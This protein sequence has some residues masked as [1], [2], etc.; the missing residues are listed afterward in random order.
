MSAI[1]NYAD[2]RGVTSNNVITMIIRTG[3][4]PGPNPRPLVRSSVNPDRRGNAQPLRWR[5]L[6]PSFAPR[7]RFAART[8]GRLGGCGGGGGDKPHD[9]GRAAWPDEQ[10]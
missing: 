1:M 7:P 4:C 8:G 10:G 9:S 5:I 6:P 2:M 3:G